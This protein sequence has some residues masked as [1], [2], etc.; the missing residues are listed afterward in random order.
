MT[1]KVASPPAQD[2][3]RTGPPN[4]KPSFPP[5]TNCPSLKVST[6][7]PT[8]EGGVVCLCFLLVELPELQKCFGSVEAALGLSTRPTL[9]SNPGWT[10][11]RHI[12]PR[13]TAPKAADSLS[14]YLGRACGSF[15]LILQGGCSSRVALTPPGFCKHFVH[16]SALRPPPTPESFLFIISSDSRGN[17]GRPQKAF[18]HFLSA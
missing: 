18:C 4:A 10:Q 12:R 14:Y 11:S 16:H 3:A 7:H 15:S 2:L 5:R 1:A 13:W 17:A 8:N 9:L 6:P